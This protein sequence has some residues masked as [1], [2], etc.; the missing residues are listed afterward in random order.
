MKS[1]LTP[2]EQQRYIR[3]I[4]LSEIGTEGQEKL[5]QGSVLCVGAG[6]LG[7]PA[8]LYLAAAGVGRIGIIDAD[9]VSVDNLQR[10]ILF[11]TEDV[12]SLKVSAAKEQLLQLNPL[13][14]IDVYSE[15]LSATNAEKIF[16][17]YDGVIDATD[18]FSTRYLINDAAIK[19][20]KPV[21]FGSIFK[22]SGQ[23]SVFSRESGCYRCLFPQ[24]PAEELAPDCNV[25]GVLGVL[26]GIVGSYQ[27]LE[28]LKWK[29][30]I[31]DI[32]TGKILAIDVLTHQSRILN[33]NRNPECRACS[34]PEKILLQSDQNRSPQNTISAPDLKKALSAK[35]ALVLLDVREESEHQLGNIGGLLLPAGNVKDNENLPA[36]L[37]QKIIVYC[38][39]GAR[40]AR[41]AE[42]LRTMG[43]ANVFN[44]EGG[45]IAWKKDVDPNL[46]L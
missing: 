44:L 38:R 7:S 11:S 17:D 29:L 18:N 39:S 25:A 22:F 16:A 23:V 4:L 28:F 36:N 15:K 41:A 35:E 12:G 46:K 13:L 3:Q 27:A 34:Q 40:S 24:P 19:L 14:Q 9:T 43:Y 30:G 8:L 33:F 6:G 37:S 21:F 42:Q 26:P 1:R 31:G 5:K 32:L 45:L 10:Q 2:E 20:N